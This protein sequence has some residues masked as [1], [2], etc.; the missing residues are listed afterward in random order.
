MTQFAPDAAV[1]ELGVPGADDEVRRGP[2]LPIDL[3][4]RLLIALLTMLCLLTLAASVQGRPVLG[5]PLWTGSV[6]LNGF[7]LGPRSLYL[8]RLDGKAVTALDLFTGRSR[9]SRDV[10]DLPD[11]IV[12]LGNG[13]AVV[14]TR[15][16]FIEGAGWQS[17]TI[18]MVRV[19]SGERIVQ[20]AGD[21]FVPS[22][23]SVDGRLLLV[24][25]RRF[26]DSDGCAESEATASCVDLAAWNVGTGAVAWRL[27]LPPNAHYLTAIVDG[28]VEA[29]A[30]IDTDGTVRLRDLST[31][32]VTGVMGLSPEVSQ[33]EGQVGLV[34]GLLLTAQ[35][36]PDG[37]H[38]DR[39]PTAVAEPEL[40]GRGAGQHG[41]ER[42]GR[43]HPAPGGVRPGRLPDGPRRAFLVD[44]PVHRGGHAADH[45]P[46]PPAARWRC[47]P[48][49]PAAWTAPVVRDGWTEE[50]IH[51]RPDRS[52][53]RRPRR[54]R[55][56]RLV[57]QRRPCP[58][59][60]RG[61]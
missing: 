44:Q 20:T 11:S 30:E 29:L 2:G 34:H 13:V 52:D 53:P 16:V 49:E 26:D 8:W 45:L 22:V 32:V 39:L 42:S 23:A 15:P 40:V 43:R 31:G 27:N 7:T 47:I 17:N 10:T 56:R 38:G 24:G 5:R 33:F 61:R 3:R 21:A 18:T 9:W 12:D 14:T 48:G 4:H 54:H 58:G 51:P 41:D 50:R 57:R 19:A 36:G 60:P 37:D 28:R 6:S 55:T 25:S 1:I 35:R 46:A 59:D